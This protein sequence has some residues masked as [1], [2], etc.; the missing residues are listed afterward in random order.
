MSMSNET[1]TT[2]ALV[3]DWCHCTLWPPV[4]IKNFHIT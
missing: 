1:L 2:L 3:L 4:T